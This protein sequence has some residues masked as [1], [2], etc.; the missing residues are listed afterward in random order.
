MTTEATTRMT[1]DRRPTATGDHQRPRTRRPTTNDD[2]RP[3]NDDR[4]T[5]ADDHRQTT[6]ALLDIVAIA[7]E[8][9]H[10]WHEPAH[11]LISIV[12][13]GG[14]DAGILEGVALLAR[15]IFVARGTVLGRCCAAPF[16]A[17][18]VPESLIRKCLT[19]SVLIVGPIRRR[20]CAVDVSFGP[21]LVAPQESRNRCFAQID[22]GGHLH[23]FFVG[24]T[25]HGHSE[26]VGRGPVRKGGRTLVLK[27]RL[28]TKKG[29]RT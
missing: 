23:V 5:A 20:S 11:A 17:Q 8:H 15:R 16:V 6:E 19:P 14:A 25:A 29:L 12:S 4:R 18:P 28:V 13:G 22:T 10:A 7:R 1:A 21:C 2:R 24:R 26:V 27:V 3:T 9:P